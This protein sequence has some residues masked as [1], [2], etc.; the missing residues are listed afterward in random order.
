M[1]NIASY[2]AVDSK[3]LQRHYKHQV[4]GYKEWNQLTH[5]EE[6]LIYPENITDKLSIDE[7]SLSKGELYT[8]VTNRNTNIKNKKSVVAV[9][10]G[11]EAKVIQAVLEKL[12]IEQRN[13]VKEV[14]MDMARNMG[15]AIKNTFPKADM[16]IDRFTHLFSLFFKGIRDS[17]RLIHV[18]RLV[19][20]AMQHL[21]VSF[22]WEAIEQEN[23]AIK[24]AKEKGEKYYP[25]V[26]SNGDTLK[27]LLARSKYLLYKLEED[28]TVNQSKR[29]ALLF[30]KYPLLEKAYKLTLSFRSIYK[31]TSKDKALT[32]FKQWKES[33]QQTKI[34]KFNTALN[35]IEYHLDNILNF[36]NNISTNANAESFNSKIKGFRANLR[37]VA[38]TSF[39]LFRLH[40]LFA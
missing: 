29:A 25:E 14:S 3:K 18:V 15:L 39:F 33:V 22:R 11:T 21:R 34:D 40:K 1:S 24:T 6:Y 26:L 17:L 12:P 37:G 16:V 8:F 5:A 30:E 20:D 28:W 7:V 2:Y 13:Q 36:F 19:M 10:N 23:A 31:N 38:D 9:I 35:S 32:Q 4:S 27:E